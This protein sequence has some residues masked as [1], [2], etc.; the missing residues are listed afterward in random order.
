MGGVKAIEDKKR[1]QRNADGGECFLGGTH[2]NRPL[3]D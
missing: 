3:D 2:M 1:R